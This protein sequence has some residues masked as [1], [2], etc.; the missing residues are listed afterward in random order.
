MTAGRLF[1]DIHT[2]RHSFRPV[3][4]F[5]VTLVA[6]AL[7]VA[8]GPLAPFAWAGLPGA[9]AL[10]TRAPYLTDL[11]ASSV[12]VNW[13]TS[14]QQRGV[15]RFGPPGNCQQAPVTASADGTAFTVSGVTEYQHSVLV[16]RLAAGTA[17]CYRITSTGPGPVDLLGSNPSPQFTTLPPA[18]ST[19]SLTF[20]VL[21]DSGDTTSNGVNNGALNQGQAAVEALIA[22]SGARFVLS[23]GD[24]SQA[25]GD[26][27]DYGDLNH[28]GPSVSAVF[29]PSYWAVP[30]QRVPLY[31]ASGNHGET[32]A[33]LA[34]WPE[35]T[36][37]TASGGAFSM[38]SYPPV[39]GTRPASY[40]A[41]YY[42]F[43]T[44]G[45]RFYVL[46]AS[47]PGDNTGTASGGACGLIRSCK[48]YQVDHDTHWTMASAEYRWLARDLAVHPGG[49]KFAFFHFP[50]HSDDSSEPSDTFLD[51]VP[52]SSGSLEQLL[53]S[54]GV[55]LVFNGHAHIY[56]RNIAAPGGV[57]SYVTGGGG[58]KPAVVAGAGCATTDVYAIG[59]S[60]TSAKGSACGAAAKP[61]SDRQV[62]HFL[63]ITV[64]G[65]RVTVTPVNSLGQ[66]FDVQTYNFAHDTIPP[67]A[68]GHLAATRAGSGATTLTWTPATDNI[69]VAAYDIYRDGMYLATVP[70]NRTT[71]TD[72][73]AVAGQRYSYRA[74]ARDL[75]G[76][77]ASAT[78]SG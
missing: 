7:A 17:Y 53:F 77:T 30:G 10:L 4:Y 6:T 48:I 47:W 61:A 14:T 59:W 37:A 60:Y 51:N 73:S 16:T 76:N 40:P 21:G 32:A 46:T 18:A 70:D 5:L 69:G 25:G 22:T 63:K 34:N 2:C 49:L 15:V 12:R 78:V 33:F 1:P 11:T 67:S 50:L 35:G 42:A 62:Y 29:G 24:I 27:T 26:Q 9:S 54:G 52:G 23:T 3:G 71:Y 41:T 44:T 57:T 28:T 19:T 72:L 65:A 43:S 36:T 55:Q 20:D 74:A 8:A 38:V 39:D 45:V 64:T 66:S 31:V 58:A 13:A 68:P 56:Q 75:A